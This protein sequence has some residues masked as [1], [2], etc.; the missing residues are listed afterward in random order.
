MEMLDWIYRIQKTY[1]EYL[2]KSLMAI[3]RPTRQTAKE[4]DRAKL[5][6][7]VVHIP[8]DQIIGVSDSDQSIDPESREASGAIVPRASSEEWQ[9]A[10]SPPPSSPEAESKRNMLRKM[11]HVPMKD[12]SD[13]RKE[14]GKHL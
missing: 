14:Q 8:E 13:H 4:K 2:H 11:K 5:S 12:T 7:K 3:K 9:L 6:D 1:M 10:S